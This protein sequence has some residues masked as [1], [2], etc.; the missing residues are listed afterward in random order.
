MKKYT[1][2]YNPD[3]LAEDEFEGIYGVSLVGEAANGYKWVMLNK[4]TQ[5]IELKTGDEEQRLLICPILIPDQ[6]IYRDWGPD[7]CT[8][9]FSKEVIKQ[10]A[11]DFARNGY[12]GNS[13]IDHK[14]DFIEGVSLVET[15]TSAD[16]DK[17][18][19]YGFELPEGS[20]VGM[21]SVD[22]TEKGDTLW[23]DYIKTGKV[24]GFSIDSYF[25]IEALLS[26]V[27]PEVKGVEMKSDNKN[28]KSNFMTNLFNWGKAKKV[29]MAT[30]YLEVEIE[31]IGKLWAEDFSK[32]YLVYSLED[33][34]KVPYTSS[35][36]VLEGKKFTTDENGVIIN[37]EDEMPAGDEETKVELANIK[38]QMAELLELMKSPGKAYVV[39]S[40]VT[41]AQSQEKV[42]L[43]IE[44][45]LWEF[46]TQ[47]GQ[48]V[49]TTW[50]SIGQPVQNE[51]K[52]LMVDATFSYQGILY[53]T[54]SEG[55]I[56]TM[57]KDENSPFWLK[58]EDESTESKE[59]EDTETES[60]DIETSKEDKKME[61]SKVDM[62]N[63]TPLELRRHQKA[64]EL[65]EEDA[66]A[67]EEDKKEEDKPSEDAPKDEKPEDKPEDKDKMI[68]D[69]KSEIEKLKEKVAS[70]EEEP[71]SVNL[72]SVTNTDMSNLRPVD[73]YRMSKRQL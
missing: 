70:L 29:S 32:G 66:P 61:L 1:I 2:T 43:D 40:D 11:H 65:A 6:E 36:F 35:E 20:W 31:G 52:E 27:K 19:M 33:D 42:N 62:S 67:K 44:V 4:Q 60:T 71:A 63:M 38:K 55:N 49:Y 28:K 58:P 23:N 5:K 12:L 8:I 17:S 72:M 51:S 15:W 14:G 68:E 50:L 73:K 59:T 9:Q 57:E 41:T 39:A 37:I 16:I 22:R 64:L 26:S 13:T 54:N 69:L 30:E 53:S 56:S 34:F 45:Q 3:E 21:M 46:E 25:G 48:K 7:G 47:D 18:Q 10:A 24:T